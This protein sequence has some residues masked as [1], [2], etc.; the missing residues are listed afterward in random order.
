MQLRCEWATT[1]MENA[2]FPWV[3]SVFGGGV[4]CKVTIIRTLKGANECLLPKDF[5]Q[6]IGIVIVSSF[7]EFAHVACRLSGVFKLLK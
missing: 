7:W 5:V 2:H 1:V 6:V 4:R 3:N